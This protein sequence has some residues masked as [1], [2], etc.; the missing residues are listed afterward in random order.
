VGVN[1]DTFV[2]IGVDADVAD[3]RTGIVVTVGIGNVGIDVKH[4]AIIRHMMISVTVNADILLQ[5]S[6][7]V[8]V[9][10]FFSW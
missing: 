10:P 2:G 5:K 1:V 9:K 4:P 7:K 3:G 6:Y 8:I